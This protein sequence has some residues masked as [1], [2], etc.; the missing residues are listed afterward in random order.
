MAPTQLEIRTRALGRLVKEYYL[1][2]EELLAQQ[3][4][5]RLL[6]SQNHDEYEI[7]KQEEVEVDTKRVMIEVSKKIN[8]LYLVLAD[9]VN[10]LDTIPTDTRENMERAKMVGLQTI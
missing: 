6:K 5:V 10:Q 9:V 4:H 8:E 2:Q 7:R 1:Y 3:N